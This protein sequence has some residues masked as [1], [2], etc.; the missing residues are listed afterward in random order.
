MRRDVSVAIVKKI[1]IK[2]S[3]SWVTLSFPFVWTAMII[4]ATEEVMIVN[5]NVYKWV[6]SHS[7]SDPDR[8]W[9]KLQL[10]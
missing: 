9:D 10:D 3:D 7:S 2:K 5:D 1:C 4:N 6:A 8:I